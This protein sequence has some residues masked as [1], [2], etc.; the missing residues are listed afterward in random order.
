ME[1]N[2]INIDDIMEMHTQDIIYSDNS[3]ESE[4]IIDSETSNIHETETVS[5]NSISDSEQIITFLE[6]QES[7]DYTEILNSILETSVSSNSILVDNQSK[8]NINLQDITFSDFSIA[9]LL[10]FVIWLTLICYLCMH[11]LFRR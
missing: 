8:A 6:R 2:I 3:Q 5:E 9:S 4:V 11:F 7:V 10:M 1:E